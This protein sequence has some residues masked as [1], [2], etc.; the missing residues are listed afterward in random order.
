MQTLEETVTIGDQDC[1]REERE[2]ASR[3][4][5]IALPSSTESG[6]SRSELA[7]EPMGDRLYPYPSGVTK[8]S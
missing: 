4:A 3:I 7:P 8:G 6:L 1:G 5:L 2:T